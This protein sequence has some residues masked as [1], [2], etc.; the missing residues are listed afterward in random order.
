MQLILEAWRRFQTHSF[1]ECHTMI[2]TE[3]KLVKKFPQR[4]V[5]AEKLLKRPFR[6]PW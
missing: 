4:S 2:Q 1:P 5:M 6:N 3:E